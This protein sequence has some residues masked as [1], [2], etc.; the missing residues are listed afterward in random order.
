M[1]L[2][3]VYFWMTEIC[4]DAHLYKQAQREVLLLQTDDRV[5]SSLHIKQ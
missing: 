1:L 2:I 3:L 4:T 5:N